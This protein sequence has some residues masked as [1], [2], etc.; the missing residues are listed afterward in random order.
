MVKK[1]KL[2]IFYSNQSN[3]SSAADSVPR[4]INFEIFLIDYSVRSRFCLIIK[5]DGL[6]SNHTVYNRN[7]AIAADSELMSL[8]GKFKAAD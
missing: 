1:N 8:R 7:I 5:C 2:L 4:I 6:P 3:T